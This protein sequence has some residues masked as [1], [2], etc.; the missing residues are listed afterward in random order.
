VTESS[1]PCAL[2]GQPAYIGLKYEVDN[3][4]RVIYFSEDK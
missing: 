4:K 1:R 2:L 3:A